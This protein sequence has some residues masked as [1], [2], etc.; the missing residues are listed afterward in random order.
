MKGENI[1]PCSV[2][3]LNKNVG[4]ISVF[5]NPKPSATVHFQTKTLLQ[6]A[7]SYKRL[8]LEISLSRAYI[9]CFFKCLYSSNVWYSLVTCTTW[10][11]RDVEFTKAH[12]TIYP[13]FAI[14]TICDE[15]WHDGGRI[16]IYNIIF[17][18]YHI[19]IWPIFTSKKI[20]IALTSKNKVKITLNFE[21]IKL[22][23]PLIGVK[24]QSQSGTFGLARFDRLY[25]QLTSKGPYN[26]TTE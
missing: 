13:S 11:K 20:L 19:N 18:I 4:S 17:V 15:M 26:P 16:W 2:F 7:L 5:L 3:I 9:V 8:L 21:S 25:K 1:V 10:I 23:S 6:W 22:Y 12:A 24:C 14:A